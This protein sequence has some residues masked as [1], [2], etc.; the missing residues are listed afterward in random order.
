MLKVFNYVCCFFASFVSQDKA[1]DGPGN[2]GDGPGTNE[3][4]PGTEVTVLKGAGL[5]LRP[6]L[7]HRT[8][9]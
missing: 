1:K 3:P 7:W 4:V 9:V 2:H 5:E 8:K 6:N